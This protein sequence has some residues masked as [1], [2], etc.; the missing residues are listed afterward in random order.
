MGKK[1]STSKCLW[2]G[3]E[4]TEEKQTPKNNTMPH[5]LKAYSLFQTLNIK[6]YLQL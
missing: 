3:A 1:H 4:H 6:Q 2:V 5:M